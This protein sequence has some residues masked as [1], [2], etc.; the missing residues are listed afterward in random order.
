MSSVSSIGIGI[1]ALVNPSWE[2]AAGIT[3]VDV[4]DDDDQ[5]FSGSA[6]WHIT[7]LYSMSLG[8]GVSD[9]VTSATLD[10]RFS[11]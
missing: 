4:F 7:K 11:F 5:T 8:V 10:A 1:R 6:R 3:H 9:D 2:L